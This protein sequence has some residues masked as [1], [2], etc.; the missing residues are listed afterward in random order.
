MQSQSYLAGNAALWLTAPLDTGYWPAGLGQ[1][2][3][4]DVAA[5]DRVSLLRQPVDFRHQAAG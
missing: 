5:A 4:H 1:Q 2:L 3:P